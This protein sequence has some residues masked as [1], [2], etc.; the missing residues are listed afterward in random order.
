MT[1]VYPILLGG[2][3]LAG[4]PVVLHFLARKKPK[5]LVFPAF[6]FL[7]QKQR[8]S[9]RNLRLKHLLLLL[10][11]MALIA[12]ACLALS[13]PRLFHESLGLSRERPVAMVLIFD[14][15]PSMNY[16]SGDVTRL[17]FTKKRA[18]ELLDE[19]SDDGRFLVLDAADPANFAREEWSRSI[20]KTRQR[21]RNLAIRPHS[22]PVTRGLDEALRRCAQLE[23]AD[24]MPRFVCVF[25]D[26]TRA[27]WNAHPEVRQP[28][29][30]KLL[31]FDVGIDKSI[32]L[33]LTH[34][35]FARGQQSFAQGETIVLNAVVKATG[36]RIR[37]TLI[38]QLGKS[39][40]KQAFELDKGAHR[41]LTFEIPS[42][43]LTPGFHQ[44][45]LRFE[46]TSDALAFNN[47]RH[48]TF[49]IHKKPRVLVLA[50]DVTSVRQFAWALEDLNCDVDRKT[51]EEPMRHHDYAAIFLVDAAAPPDALWQ[52]L[53]DY[54]QEY[55]VCVIPGGDRLQ[56][57]AYNSTAARKLLPAAF[58][59]S[60][61]ADPGSAWNLEA[62]HL[63]HPFTHPFRAWIDLPNL[64]FL[65]HPRL[66]KQYWEVI[67][68]EKD[69]DIAVVVAYQDDKQRPAIVERLMPKGGKVLLLTTPMDERTPA[70]NN[71]DQRVTS[72]YITLTSLCARHLLAEPAGARMN[73]IFGQ[74]PPVVK[75]DPS[76]P[77]G[78]LIGPDGTAEIRFDEKQRWLGDRLTKAGHYTVTGS[79]PEAQ[80][81]E[82]LARFSINEASEE[83]DL[84]R[85]P[86]E[87]IETSLGK[88]SLIAQ[89]RR[90]SLLE[91][92]NDYW[93]E[94]MELFPWLMIGILFLLALENLLANRFY[95][96]DAVAE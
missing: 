5:T 85:I 87:E 71:Y 9:T 56:P 72:F 25:S 54:A 6:Q 14:T 16:Q 49:A 59:A 17:D 30:V 18:L 3:L 81:T 76:L 7:M 92:I 46:T 35:E 22:V 84:S 95:R 86:K 24:R 67:P 89:Y 43:D 13:R 53:A 63:Q 75:Q 38:C 28:G 31:Y 21:V 42:A 90:T 73:H 1:F 82:V 93:D 52:K 36:D 39:E 61:K 29:N 45:K 68:P 69:K 2:L 47:V 15:T 48:V 26:R 94:P 40:F 50:D 78:T 74:T 57:R 8:Q 65:R 34:A 19:L 55:G 37:N 66:A 41:T 33:A 10:M 12:L 11:R 64:D 60:I 27:S 96:K 32:D 91:S 20:E 79:N 88:D 58:G 80:K 83:S 70:W 77:K 23:D 62:N 51:L 4:L 44:A